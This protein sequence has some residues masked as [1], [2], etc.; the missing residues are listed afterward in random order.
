MEADALHR[1]AGRPWG[2]SHFGLALAAGPLFWGALWLGGAPLQ[3]EWVSAHLH[4]FVL[5]CLIY[6][7]V[8]EWVFRGVLQEV[9]ARRLSWRLGILSGAN[10]LASAGFVA[11]HLPGH[12]PLWAVSALFPSLVFG[13][14]K[15]RHGTLLAPFAL[16]AFYNAGYFILFGAGSM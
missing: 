3:L 15:E 7:L 6:P 2:D 13:Y 1:Y 11:A 14:F 10:L 16:H 5:F 8:E 9:I 12:P 4:L